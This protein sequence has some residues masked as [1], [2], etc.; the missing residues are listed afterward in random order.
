MAQGK[1]HFLREVAFAFFHPHTTLCLRQPPKPIHLSCKF[2]V[3]CSG[4]H[5]VGGTGG[6][7]RFG[8]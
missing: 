6:Q 7:E 5:D 8:R 1:V 4:H 2:H 3:V